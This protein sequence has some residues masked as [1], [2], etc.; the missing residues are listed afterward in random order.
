M[1]KFLKE[2]LTE[3]FFTIMA[4]NEEHIYQHVGYDLNYI[5]KNYNNIKYILEEEE[6]DI[7]EA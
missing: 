6:E 3:E 4:R 1:M 7:P 5:E 2:C